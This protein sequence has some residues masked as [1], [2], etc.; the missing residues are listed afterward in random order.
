MHDAM[1]QAPGP[2]GLPLI[3]NTLDLWARDPREVAREGLDKMRA[4]VEG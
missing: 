3:R 2:R 4:V 1:P